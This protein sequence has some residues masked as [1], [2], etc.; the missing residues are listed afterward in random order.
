MSARRGGTRRMRGGVPAQLILKPD[1]L[2]RT[3]SYLDGM[4]AAA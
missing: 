4:R 1:G 3:L 2:T